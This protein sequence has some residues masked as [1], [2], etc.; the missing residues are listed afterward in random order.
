M[1]KK[2]GG[3]KKK[4][5]GKKAKEPIDPKI[6]ERAMAKMPPPT[7]RG[8]QTPKFCVRVGE[9]LQLKFI[10]NPDGLVEHLKAVVVNPKQPELSGL[11]A[12]NEHG[13]TCLMRAARDGMTKHVEKLLEAGA[14]ASVESLMDV[15]EKI[16]KSGL[17]VPE[18]CTAFPAGS[19]A[20]DLAS[21]H[22]ASLKGTASEV[23][24]FNYRGAWPSPRGEL[25][26]CACSVSVGRLPVPRPIVSQSLC[27][28]VCA[29][30]KEKLAEALEDDDLGASVPARHCAAQPLR[31]VRDSQLRFLV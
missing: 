30:I 15:T 10:S 28:S 16:L 8:E 12:T 21:L 24:D 7:P 9:L 1:P 26:R 20:F 25:A 27:R 3:G 31:A 29:A 17:H 2:K 14:D 22:H 6:L 5:G 13:W 19:T 23:T 18:N 4:K 11:D